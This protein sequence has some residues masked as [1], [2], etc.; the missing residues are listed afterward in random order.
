MRVEWW[1][2]VVPLV[3]LGIVGVWFFLPVVAN[4]PP[5]L[6]VACLNNIRQIGLAMIMYAQDHEGAYPSSF[7]VL[8][9][10]GY[11]PT[12]RL[13]ICPASEDCIPEDFP[14]DFKSAD[15]HVLDSVEQWGSYV[16]V[17]GLTHEGRKDVI[18]LH[19]KPGNHGGEGRNCYFDDG[20]VRWLPE[21]E[22]QR[23][24]KVQQVK[25]REVR[26]GA[27]R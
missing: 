16:M 14:E 13:L 7:G 5:S 6:R 25:L 3:L 4:G 9:K 23:H 19:D 8:L 10:G 21:A 11:L 18:I 1:E 20:H 15:L 27:P 12:P 17:K 24:M 22:F 26:S 2:I